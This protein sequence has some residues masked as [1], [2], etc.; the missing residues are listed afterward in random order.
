MISRSQLIIVIGRKPPI[1]LCRKFFQFY[2]VK[3]VDTIYY[4]GVFLWYGFLDVRVGKQQR[5]R[6]ES[7]FDYQNLNLGNQ[8]YKGFRQNI[9]K[10]VFFQKP[11]KSGSFSINRVK[12]QKWGASQL[13]KK[14]I[15]SEIWKNIHYF[16]QIRISI[17]LEGNEGEK[18]YRKPWFFSYIIIEILVEIRV[19][20]YFF[21]LEYVKI[22]FQTDS[23]RN[24]I[25]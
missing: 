3:E 23:R 8:K 12:I 16:T 18:F 4:H 15:L 6:E 11:A 19:C 1:G 5:I 14:L 24:V 25:F 13:E 10:Y 20:E 7:G 2:K 9:W 21:Y 17:E 22:C